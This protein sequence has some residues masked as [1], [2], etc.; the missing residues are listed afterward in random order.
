MDDVSAISLSYLLKNAFEKKLDI[1][2]QA[3]SICDFSID[4]MLPEGL[5]TDIKRS[6]VSQFSEIA[7]PLIGIG[8]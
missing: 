5:Y 3:L 8:G 2:V 6:I 7:Y 4:S 1:R